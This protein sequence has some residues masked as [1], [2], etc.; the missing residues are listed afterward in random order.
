MRSAN[1]SAQILP[2]PQERVRHSTEDYSPE[3]AK[4]LIATVG[5]RAF[6]YSDDAMDALAWFQW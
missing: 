1:M 5:R 2:F 4:I 3:P 6:R